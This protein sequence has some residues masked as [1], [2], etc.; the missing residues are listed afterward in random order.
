VLLLA[1]VID[2]DL[3]V[4]FEVTP[5][6][7]VLFYLGVFGSIMAGARGMVPD[8]NRVFDP[9]LLMEEVIRYTHYMPD[10]WKDQMHSKQVSICAC[11]SRLLK[12]ISIF[13]KVHQEFGE[14][15]AMKIAIFVQELVSVVLTPFVL[16]FSLPQCAPAIIDFF[17]DFTVHIPGRGYVCSFAEFD[18]VRHGNVKVRLFTPDNEEKADAITN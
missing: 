18:F 2:P 17:H 13:A 7:T 4:H 8:D 9:E 10:E 11:V 16:W 12:L 14:L 15:F 1:S 3:F 5:H 6:R